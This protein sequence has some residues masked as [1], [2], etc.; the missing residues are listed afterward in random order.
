MKSKHLQFSL[1]ILF[2]YLLPVIL[3]WTGVIPFNYRFIVLVAMAVIVAFYSMISKYSMKD[4]GFRKDNLIKAMKVNGILSLIFIG[5]MLGAF[6]LDLIREP[7]VPAWDAFFIFYI[8]IS[9]PAQEFL[10]RSVIFK[11]L[12]KLKINNIY[13]RVLITALNYSLMHIFYN[14]LITLFVPFTIGIAWGFI[15]NKYPNFWAVAFSHAIL[16]VVSIIVGLI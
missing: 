2:F 14:D 12:D 3:L 13:Y 6:K 1:L 7:T 15:Y 11:E 4:L 16:G 5:L 10:Y 8:F 9:S